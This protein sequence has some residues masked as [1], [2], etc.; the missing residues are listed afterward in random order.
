MIAL[1]RQELAIVRTI[2]QRVVPDRE[3]MV[4]G[5]RSRGAA[6]PFS[7][8]DLAIMG[9]CPLPLS[10]HAELAHA[11]EESLLPFKVDV[12]DWASLSASFRGVIAPQLVPLDVAS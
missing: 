2:L 3:V 11:F 12:V 9:E 7:D 4:F 6:K 5:S 8:L 1:T 10:V